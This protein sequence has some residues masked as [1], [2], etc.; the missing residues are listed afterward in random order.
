MSTLADLVAAYD[1]P[2]ESGR[3]ELLD[4]IEDQGGAE[5]AARLAASPDRDERYLAA[6]LMHLLPARGH[7]EPLRALVADRDRE[8]AA[9]ARRAL[10]TQPRTE[11]WRAAVAGLAESTDAELRA[12]AAGWLA[13]A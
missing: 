11:A 5:Q 3:A 2:R 8:V 13:E 9:A 10:R 12:A 6:R 7:L 4:A 1:T